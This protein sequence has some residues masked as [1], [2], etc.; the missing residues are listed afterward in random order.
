MKP[1]FAIP[2]LA[3]LATLAQPASEL[4]K[5]VTGQSRTSSVC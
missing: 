4:E 2:A 3:R 5:R 1:C